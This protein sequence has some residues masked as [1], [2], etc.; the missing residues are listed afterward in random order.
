MKYPVAAPH[1]SGREAFYVNECLRTNWISSQGQFINRFEE[2]FAHAVNRKH[3]VATCNGTVA[4]HLALLGLGVGPGDE[5]IVPSLTY[6]ATANAV[7]YCGATPVFADCDPETWCLSPASVA[8]LISLR[9]KG[10]IPVHLYGHPC[11]MTALLELADA[12]QLWVMEDCAEAFGA[13]F[14]GRPV[15]SFGAASMFSF[16]G[17]KILTTGEGGMVV[18]DDDQLA[19]RL[20]LVKG[21][22]MDPARRYWHPII[23]YN[24]RMTNIA[25]AIGLGQLE[26]VDQL[27]G[28]RKR[29]AGW[30]RERLRG[31]PGL[32]LPVE[33]P[34]ASNIFWL[35]SI[36]LDDPAWRNPLMTELAQAGIETRPLFYPVHVFPMY[37]QCRTDAGCEVAGDLSAR[38]INLPTSSYLNEED[39][40]VITGELRRVL[41]RFAGGTVQAPYRTAA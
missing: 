9:T 8:R 37:R 25:A 6:I 14:D 11:D 30:Y 36:L 16:F 27:M 4:L 18:T 39:I 10:I 32:T 17:N 22:G 24:Y 35:Y 40:D 38:G 31:F 41:E 28:D 34:G 26:H 5:V 7:A 1:L 21:Q 33:A 20:R 15:G 13:T 3:A 19:A 2:Q 29:I 23:G 12:H